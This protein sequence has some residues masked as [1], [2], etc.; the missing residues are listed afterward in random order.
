MTQPEQNGDTQDVSVF[1]G[2]G[3]LDENGFNIFG[4][5]DYRHGN[6]VMAKDR[7]VSKRGGLLPELGITKGS[8]GSFPAN[9]YDTKLEPKETHMQQLDAGITRSC[10]LKVDSA[11]ITV[12]Q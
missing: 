2:Y 11:V 4:V 12:K 9:F 8:S 5:V 3:D 6:D 7:K 10:T 1:G